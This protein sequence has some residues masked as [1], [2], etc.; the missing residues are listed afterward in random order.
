ML[1]G[2]KKY[3]SIYNRIRYLINGKSGIMLVVS[4][5][6]VQI[7]VDSQNFLLLEKIISFHNV[8]IL[9]SSVWNKDKNNYYNNIFLQKASYQL[10][11]NKFLYKI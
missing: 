5:S 7:K 3:N 9:I 6:Y 10:L 4:H 2:S 1:F 8:I 11:K